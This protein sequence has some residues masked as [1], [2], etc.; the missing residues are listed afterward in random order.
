MAWHDSGG[1][2][3]SGPLRIRTLL[4]IPVTLASAC[5]PG[6][7]GTLLRSGRGGDPE[8][9]SQQAYCDV[10]QRCSSKLADGSPCTDARQCTGARC[11]SGKCAGGAVACVEGR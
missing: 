10:T 11:E 3:W 6:P 5:E 7:G 8:F 1:G 2:P 4:L 9:C